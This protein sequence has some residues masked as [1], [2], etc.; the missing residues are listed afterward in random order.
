MLIY[1]SKG[2]PGVGKLGG[3]HARYAPSNFGVIPYAAAFDAAFVRDARR[4]VG[5]VYLQNDDLPNPWD[6]LPPFFGDL[7]AALE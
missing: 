7:L 2:L 4:F 6:T 3:W 1:E 5:F